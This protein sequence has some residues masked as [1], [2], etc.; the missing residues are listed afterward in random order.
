M[1]EEIIEKKELDYS[2]IGL[3]AGLEIHQQ[4]DT[5]KLFSRTPSLLRSDKPDYIVRRKLH[6]VAGEEGEIDD[7]VKHEASLDKEFEYE[8][9]NDTIS[10]IVNG[11][12]A[13]SNWNK[14]IP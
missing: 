13:K 7:A 1:A 12:F 14:I 6:A 5:G 2:K 10:L 3:K 11:C 9:Y 4:L 8:G